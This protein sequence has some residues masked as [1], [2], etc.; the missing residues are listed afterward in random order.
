[1]CEA[2]ETCTGCTA[3]LIIFLCIMWFIFIFIILEVSSSWALSERMGER[4]ESWIEKLPH[5][6]SED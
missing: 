1:M 6:K 2:T 5:P 4:V 3:G